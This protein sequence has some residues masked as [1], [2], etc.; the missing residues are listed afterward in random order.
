M[1]VDRDRMRRPFCRHFVATVGQAATLN[2]ATRYANRGI[3][4]EKPS[5]ST[6]AFILLQDGPFL[7]VFVEALWT[8]NW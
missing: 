7:P 3:S 1:F 6:L 5:A 2:P 4:L 8:L